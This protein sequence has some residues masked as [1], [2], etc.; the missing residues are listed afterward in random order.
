[1][2]MTLM[3][4]NTSGMMEHTEN[5]RKLHNRAGSRRSSCTRPGIRAALLVAT[6]FSTIVYASIVDDATAMEFSVEKMS[7]GTR[8]M[9][10]TGEIMPEDADKFKRIL[11]TENMRAATLILNSPGGSVGAAMSIGRRIRNN[12]M[13]TLVATG[14]HCLSA[15]LLAF[16]GGSLRQVADG[17]QIGSHQFQWIDSDE[18]TAAAAASAT[19]ELSASILWH[20]LGLGVRAEGYAYVMSTPAD[21]MRIFP[22]AALEAY[23]IVGFPGSEDLPSRKNVT[24]MPHGV[25]KP[26]CPF[27]A[28]FVNLDPLGIYPQCD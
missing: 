13:N 22:K 14:E 11:H 8:Y 24:V 25:K 23:N 28:D 10:A 9:T 15:C 20:F 18:M 3:A 5:K 6:T 21:R 16:L 2:R 19:Q 4:P 26:G 17:G 1:M 12:E 27:P 7:D